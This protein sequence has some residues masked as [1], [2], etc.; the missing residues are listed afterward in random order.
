MKLIKY[1]LLVVSVLSD[2]LSFNRQL[3]AN[4]RHVLRR[5]RV[6]PNK[7]FVSL[8]CIGD[9]CNSE[10]NVGASRSNPG[11][12]TGPSTRNII[13]SRRRQKYKRMMQ[14]QPWW[15]PRLCPWIPVMTV[16]FKN[17]FLYYQLWVQ[18]IILPNLIFFLINRNLF[19]DFRKNKPS[20]MENLKYPKMIIG[21]TV[22]MEKGTWRR[23]SIFCQSEISLLRPNSDY[24]AWRA[25]HRRATFLSF[26]F[27]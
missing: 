12:K 18:I 3:N 6:R 1:F 13:K 10:D 20:K 21:S 16:Y 5:N 17:L 27:C 4:R 14:S 7:L 15:F 22:K 9:N 25:G 23:H 19:H 8:R 24:H 2:Q 26:L 11:V